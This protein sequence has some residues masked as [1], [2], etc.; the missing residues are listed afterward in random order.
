MPTTQSAAAAS[1]PQAGA[2][3]KAEQQQPQQALSMDAGMGMGTGSSG[4]SDDGVRLQRALERL[5][6]LV[7][8]FGLH[9]LDP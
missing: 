5:Q 8:S 4:V 2:T 1:H 3:T 6:A 9:M 7:V